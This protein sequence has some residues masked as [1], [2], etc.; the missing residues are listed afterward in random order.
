MEGDEEL[1]NDHNNQNDAS[2]Q[3]P[4]RIVVMTVTT[5]MIFPNCTICACKANLPY[6]GQT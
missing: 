1:Q 5:V 6:Y 3:E 2:G 4:Q